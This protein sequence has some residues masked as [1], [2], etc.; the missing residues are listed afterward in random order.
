MYWYVFSGT[1]FIAAAQARPTDTGT[2]VSISPCTSMIG[3]FGILPRPCASTVKA[4]GASAAAAAH[5]CGYLI[6]RYNVPAPPMEW[7]ITY[8]RSSSTLNSLR[9]RS[10]TS[11][12]SFSLSS[13]R[14]G[15]SLGLFN[16]PGGSAPRRPCGGAAA[17]FGGGSA[18]AALGGAGIGAA[19]FGA[20]AF[21]AG[22]APR[23][24][25]G[26]GAPYQ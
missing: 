6:A 8:V 23:R 5:R 17:P 10:T 13:R 12:V 20:V 18:A 4:A 11:S 2:T 14:F 7:P 15:G 26:A 25:P 9:T 19:A 24:P 3:I 16:R 22:G 1:A 21:G